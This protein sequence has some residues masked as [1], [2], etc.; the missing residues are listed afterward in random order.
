M[1]MKSQLLMMKMAVTEGSTKKRELMRNVKV[2]QWRSISRHSNKSRSVLT[3][4]W[5]VQW[6]LPMETKSR[7]SLHQVAFE[8]CH[9]GVGSRRMKFYIKIAYFSGLITTMLTN[10]RLFPIFAL[11]LVIISVCSS[12]TW[13]YIQFIVCV[14]HLKQSMN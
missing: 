1:M 4:C 12:K 3:F 5:R 9:H 6:I 8:L 11:F 7:I 10:V 2:H 13:L 14:D